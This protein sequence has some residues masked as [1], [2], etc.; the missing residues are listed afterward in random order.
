MHTKY[1]AYYFGEKPVLGLFKRETPE[2]KAIRLE[3]QQKIQETF[4]KA[5]YEAQLEAAKRNGKVAGMKGKRSF[6]DKLNDVS[7][8]LS[9]SSKIMENALGKL[10]S[11]SHE[12]SLILPKAKAQPKQTRSSQP[13]VIVL[14]ERN[15]EATQKKEKTMRE[16][17]W[18]M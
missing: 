2:H 13:I 11:G 17:I 10:P 18:E 4:E 8:S 12:E 7:K 1:V 3:H 16:R 5:K 14:D 6:M 9:E 15:K